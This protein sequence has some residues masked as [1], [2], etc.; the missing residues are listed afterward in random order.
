MEKRKTK[1]FLILVTSLFC[2]GIA[3]AVPV[4]IKITGTITS[5][6]DLEDYPYDEIINIGDTFTGT[7]SYNSATLDSCTSSNYGC[8]SYDSPYGFNVSLGGLEFKT[9]DSHDDQF[10]IAI[11]ND[12]SYDRYTVESSQN[13]PL[14]TGIAVNRIAWDIYDDTHSA[15]SSDS[16]TTEAPIINAWSGNTF[17]IGCGGFPGGNA[18]FAIWG[19]VTNAEVIPEPA[20]L[21]ILC[22]GGLLVRTR[23]F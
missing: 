7:Y 15:L 6:R 1:L 2:Y 8:Y 3:E 18:T 11:C 22:L 5:I 20:T 19:T 17:S 12:Y 9:V 13:T 14:S 10:K 23:K 16:L 4:T 21:A